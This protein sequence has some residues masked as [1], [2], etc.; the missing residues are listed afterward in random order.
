MDIIIYVI[1]CAIMLLVSWTGVRFI[2]KKS[3]AEMTS[4]D[5]A[6]I[7]LLTTVAAEPLVYKISS[8]ATVGVFTIFILTYIIGY[9]SLNKFFYNFDSKPAIV[10]VDGKVIEKELKRARMNIPL[11]LSELRIKGYQNL[12]DVKYAIVE[13]SGK[14]S[15]IAK[16][17][18]SP[19]TPKQMGIPSA[20]VNLSFSLII[21]GQVDDKNLNFLQKDR[22]W[23]LDQLKAFQIGKF[24]DVLIAQ[25]DSSG[26][27]YVSPKNKTVNTPNIS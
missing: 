21:D 6:A 26:Q 25:Y 11:I 15:V 5:L 10:I 18:V 20:P 7:M 13:P 24:E 14:L 2:G 22:K 19:V 4:Y 12:S 27:L 17:Q 16:S 23:L 8:K 9:L 3:I 1:R